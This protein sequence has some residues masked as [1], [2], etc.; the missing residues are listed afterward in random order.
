MN[1][2]LSWDRWAAILVI[3]PMVFLSSCTGGQRPI[4]NPSTQACE[5]SLEVFPT[6]SPGNYGSWLRG[7]S[8]AGPNDAW[9]VGGY[10]TVPPEWLSRTQP[11]GSVLIGPPP[12][13]L[14]TPFVLR[15]DGQTWVQASTPNAN[16]RDIESDPVG[17]TSFE[18][19]AATSADDAWAVGGG[20]GPVIQHWDGDMWSVIASP[21]VN[22]VNGTLMT[23]SADRADN[24]WAAGSGSV[25][26]D[27][28]GPVIEHWDGTE[29]VVTPVLGIDTRYSMVYD[30]A[31]LSPTDVWVV[32]Q[33]WDRALML[34][35]DGRAWS[36]VATPKVRATRLAA[37]AAV[38]S[39]NIWAVGSSFADV[40]GNG[41]T[42]G[43]IQHW[44]GR[45]WSLLSPPLL[46][47]GTALGSVTS[48]GSN[49]VWAAGT[50]TRADGS[51]YQSLVLHYDGQRW[52]EVEESLLSGLFLRRIVASPG[53][54]VWGIG[55]RYQQASTGFVARLCR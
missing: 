8:F 36:E 41:P 17:G 42:Q 26:G 12:P 52:V 15:W 14:T 47:A 6:P 24:A 37:I 43:L 53:G 34:H 29:W 22:L 16:V 2:P 25:G 13:T 1:E 27:G 9:A 5:A 20:Q 48:N 30:I 35:W 50:R 21:N 18:D 55:N 32:G 51:S 3:L 7:V 28:I 49:D 33:Q 31:A 39:D 54:H 11:P 44:D 45:R 4:P 23:V 10:Q 40:D 38:S 46:T 19:V